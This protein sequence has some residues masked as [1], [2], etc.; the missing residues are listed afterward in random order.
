MRKIL[1]MS[2]AERRELYQ[3]SD[4]F[5]R[6]VIAQRT[7]EASAAFLIP[8]LRPGMRLLD[9]GCGPGNITVDLAKLVAPGEVVGV[10]LSEADLASGRDLALT[11]GVANVRFEQANLYWLPFA[12]GAFD[13]AFAHSVLE[14]LGDPLAAL[15]EMRRVLRS[16]GMVGIA[17]PA[18]H[19]TLRYPTNAW[20]DMW[21]TLRPRAVERRGGHPLYVAEQRALLRQ[22]GFDRSEG[23]AM[24]SGAASGRGPAGTREDTRR[25]AAAE[26][27]RLR[28][29]FSVVA[30]EDGWAN[31]AE[32][33]AMAKALIE[34]GEHPDAY[35]LRPI[36]C[37]VGWA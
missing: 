13:V 9:C 6:D 5:R 8:H 19:R 11:R 4:E 7:A 3:M 36:V 14:H 1:A 34:W 26:V 17:D 28:D 27:A 12:D 33:D 18:W 15:K 37:A 32:L 31:Q 35:L 23:F 21:D 29:D 24:A 20:L 16:G 10:D 2:E 25:A 30:L 22:A